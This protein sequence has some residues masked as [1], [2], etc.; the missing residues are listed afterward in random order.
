MREMRTKSFVDGRITNEAIRRWGTT[1]KAIYECV[2][3]FLVDKILFVE[4][5]YNI[6]V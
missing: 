1:N 4:I 2:Y 5:V 3:H 6:T